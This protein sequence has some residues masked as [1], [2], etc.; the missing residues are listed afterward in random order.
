MKIVSLVSAVDQNIEEMLAGMHLETDA[1]IVNQCVTGDGSADTKCVTGA[2]SVDTFCTKSDSE[3]LPSHN[4]SDRT[5]PVT[6][7]VITMRERGVGLSRNT[8]I[9]NAPDCD[10][11]LFTDE[12]IVYDEGYS[13]LI[14][15]EYEA[16]PEADALLF[17]MRVCEARRTYWNDDFA[18]VRFYN[19]GRYPAYSISVRRDRLFAS[20]V[21][22]PLEFGG[23]ARYIN[24]EDSVFLHDLLKAGLKIYRT[25]VCLGEETERESTWFKGYDERFFVSRGALYVRLYGVWALLRAHVFLIRH[26]YMYS[27][28]GY[29]QAIRWMKQGMREIRLSSVK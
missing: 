9:E 4:V 10:I 15:R 6:H 13:E 16:H 1:V 12:D 22:F 7:F 25:T 20:G 8:C 5:V 11:L 3:E 19:Y 18:R 2:G 21:R 29:G 23:G 26:K 24:G 27:E 28:A 14:R 17:N